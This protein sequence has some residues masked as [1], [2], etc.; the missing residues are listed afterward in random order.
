MICL[1]SSPSYFS[2]STYSCFV[3]YYHYKVL[4]KKDELADE[5]VLRADFPEPP[6]GLELS[7]SVSVANE[8]ALSNE[9]N[10]CSSASSS[11]V[12]SLADA[13]KEKLTSPRIPSTGFMSHV[14]PANLQ[15]LGYT[16]RPS[17]EN[18]WTS[19]M[20]LAAAGKLTLSPRSL[21]SKFSQPFE[22]KRIS[23]VVTIS[24]IIIFRLSKLWKATLI[25]RAVWCNISGKGAGEIWNCVLSSKRIERKLQVKLGVL[26][27]GRAVTYG[28]SRLNLVAFVKT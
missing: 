4:S 27:I 5:D 14:S 15:N 2:L 24:S 16:R 18:R 9:M 17:G 7:D 21:K 20:S 19:E 10:S 23:E 11:C 8:R 28:H 25:L 13:Y 12:N 3:F 26:E 1:S 6:V 22:E